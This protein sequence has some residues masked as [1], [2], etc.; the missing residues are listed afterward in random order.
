MKQLKDEGMKN[1]RM[2]SN[3]VSVGTIPVWSS[4]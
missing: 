2:H 4:L 3:Q 1:E